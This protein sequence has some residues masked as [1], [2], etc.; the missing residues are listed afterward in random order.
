MSLSL[1]GRPEGKT[2]LLCL[3]A[4][5]S[6]YLSTCS[7]I[8]FVFCRLLYSLLSLRSCI[9]GL[10]L[11]FRFVSGGYPFVFFAAF[12]SSSSPGCRLRLLSRFP[13]LST[14]RFFHTDAPSAV[15]RDPRFLRLFLRVRALSSSFRA[16]HRQHR[17][18]TARGKVNGSLF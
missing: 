14:L 8:A 7:R 17:N 11:P 12:L 6:T 10:S 1:Q 9:R 13:P 18:C 15:S 4:G 5:S 2:S 16:Q 3:L